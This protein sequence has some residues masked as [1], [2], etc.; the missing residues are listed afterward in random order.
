MLADTDTIKNDLRDVVAK[1][2]EKRPETIG[3]NTL[4]SE[5]GADSMMMLE[6]LVA[7]ERKYNIEIPE[8]S[9]PRM[10]NLN[11]SINIIKSLVRHR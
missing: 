8:E 10:V 3:D 5:L 7:I 11:D 1:I 2:V 9:L 6:V 4:F